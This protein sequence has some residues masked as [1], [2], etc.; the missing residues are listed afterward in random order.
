MKHRLDSLLRPASVAVVGASPRAGSM[1]HW[2]LRNL[3]RGDFPGSVFAVNPAYANIDGQR[4]FASL[5]DLPSTPELVIFAVG[6][7]HVEG[8]LD[9][10]IEARIPAAVIMSSLCLDDDHEPNLKERV[11]A[12]IHAAGMLLCGANGMGFY[13]VRD[14]T[15]ACGFDSRHH[16][17]G[18]N[19][20]LISQSGAGMSGLIDCDERIGINFAVSTGN[21]ISVTM[22]QY[23]DF[24]LELP[25]TKVV[26]LFLETAKNPEGLRAAFEKAVGMRIPLVALKVGRTPYAAELAVSHSGALAG[27]DAT[28]S[29]LFERYGVHRVDDMDELATALILFATCNPIGPGGLV[30]LH[31]SGGERQLL[32]DLADAANVPLTPLSARTKTRLRQHLDVELPALNPLDA[33][34]RG[35]AAAGNRM[36]NC[37]SVMMQDDAAALG[38]VI[39]DRGPEGT[40]YP[41]YVEYLEHAR[42]LSSKP[43]ALV[44]ARQGTGSDP[45]VSAT[46]KR[47]M[48]VLDGVVPFLRGVRGLMDYRAFLERRTPASPISMQQES[49]GAW[50]ERLTSSGQ[51][52]EF[53]SL[54]LLRDAGID[55]VRCQKVESGRELRAAAD[56][57]TYPLVLKTA[58]PG[59]AH[60]TE[61]NGVVLNVGNAAELEEA[62]ADL[63]R[64]LGP[65][66]LL[67]EQVA[68]GSEMFL[69]ARQDPQFGP[70]VVIGFGG[71]LAEVLQDVTFALPPFTAADASRYVGQLRLRP[72][73]DGVRGG[74]PHAV[75]RFCTMAERF[76][77]LVA[78]LG[79]TFSEID[80]NPVIVT[81]DR[82]VAVDALVVGTAGNRQGG[83]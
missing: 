11:S 63:E 49:I 83:Q 79:R 16:G 25:E 52:G 72:V 30:T 75:A 60:K 67:A 19:I 31:D 57:A 26:G 14:R 48:P 15:W 37:F 17:P 23:L 10:A 66:A 32:V 29:A 7:K 8:V 5:A 59:I 4:C 76:A 3:A 68:N 58:V 18:G 22:D 6:D 81:E 24:A 41:S 21:E 71:I 47:G 78:A 35:G 61:R 9:Q 20:S 12:K 27:D 38:A 80:I 73:L 56:A 50:A 13:N 36:M 43:V 64:R 45:L 1:G 34:S 53:D 46:T 55:T 69:G 54:S 82:S 51:L 62:Y 77:M 39:H 65:A 70:L 40:I 42:A 44:A 28:Y 33:W 74:S 2:A